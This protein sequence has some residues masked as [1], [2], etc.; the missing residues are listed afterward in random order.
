[1]ENIFGT[2]LLLVLRV[3]EITQ[4]D[5][6]EQLGM[7]E[8]TISN[9]IKGKRMPSLDVAMKIA[10]FLDIDINWFLEERDHMTVFAPPYRG[11]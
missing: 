3:K 9:Y 4:K 11:K 5:L 2:N 7:S 10:K 1:M 6:A 8:S